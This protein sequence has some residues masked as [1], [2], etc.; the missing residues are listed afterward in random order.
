V[1]LFAPNVRI[2]EKNNRGRLYD[3]GFLLGAS[4]ALGGGG[5]QTNA[6]HFVR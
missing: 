1:G 5:S 6:L 3:F 2:Y 4:S